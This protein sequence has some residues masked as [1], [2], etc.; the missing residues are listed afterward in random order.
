MSAKPLYNLEQGTIP[1]LVSIPH[2]GTYIPD[3]INSRLTPEAQQQPDADWHLQRL[4]AFVTEMGGSLLT[5]THSRYA[6]DLNRP[7]NDES[8]Y[9]GQTTTG[10]CP[11][12]MFRGGAVYKDGKRLSPEE[13]EERRKTYW[14]P[15]HNALQNELARLRARHKNVLLWEGH[16]IARTLPRLFQGSLPD[17]NFGTSDGNACSPLIQA[18]VE[19]EAKECGYSYV[20]N[21]RFKG[22]YI[23]RQYGR[24]LN[25]VHAIQLEMSQEIYMKEEFPFS[26]MEELA[27][28]LE[29]VLKKLVQR[30]IETVTAL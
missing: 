29:P 8:L 21:G 10:L 25:G 13:T 22:G 17:F 6:V 2:C 28:R 24:P 12:Q 5:A 30:G 16:S 11:D 14:E 4:Y 27:E 19:H 9:P 15:Y 7:P 20:F 23:T 26:C 1:L 3:S 18:A